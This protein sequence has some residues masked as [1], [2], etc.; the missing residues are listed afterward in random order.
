LPTLLPIGAPSRDDPA[1]TTPIR[2]GDDENHAAMLADRHHP[3]LTVV[4]ASVLALDHRTAEDLRCE[5]KAE[6][7]LPNVALVL[8]FVPFKDHAGRLR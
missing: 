7:A 5:A 1:H 4:L 6:A 3:G 2:I 8:G